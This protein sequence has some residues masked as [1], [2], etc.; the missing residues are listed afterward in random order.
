MTIANSEAGR[1][2][3]I[4]RGV[5]AACSRVIYN[6]IDE[7][8]L[9][10]TNTP[11]DLLKKYNIPPYC[12]IVGMVARMFPQKDPCNF[13]K[14][15]ECVVSQ[16]PET[17]FFMVGDGPILPKV[18]SFAK[19]LNLDA[20]VIF[21]GNQ[22]HVA[23]FINVMDVVVLPSRKSEG[24]SNALIEAMSLG[25][26]SIATDIPGNNELFISGFNGLLVPPGNFKELANNI[27]DL[28]G[29]KNF[30]NEIGRNAKNFAREQ[31]S[32]KKMI[33]EHQNLYDELLTQG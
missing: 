16:R 24:C 2:F 26:A 20:F 9:S 15:A 21:T 17:R 22:E 30:I 33:Q 10:S 28:L 29:N 19:S 4:S 18:K 7:N 1:R 12:Q 31:F 23:D 13:L 3:V 14:A 25:K 27:L 32:Q 8:R 6:G 11:Q 5:P